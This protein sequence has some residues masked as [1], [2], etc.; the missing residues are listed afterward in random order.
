LNPKFPDFHQGRESQRRGSTMLI[1][2]LGLMPYRQAWALQEEAHAQVLT[3]GEERVLLVE[4]PPVITFGRRA[5]V[6]RNLIASEEQLA[7]M[8]VEVVQSDRGGDITFHGPGQIVAYPIVRLNDHRLS[9]GGYVHGLERAV[10]DTLADLAIPARVDPAAVG[11]WTDDGGKPAKVC[12]IGVR[13]KRGVS[14]HGV[15]L[16][17]ETDLRYFDLI[18]PCG[19]AESA[20]TSIAKLQGIRAPSISVV[21]KSLERHLRHWLSM[22]ISTVSSGRV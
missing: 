2:D 7:S 10:I 6:A 9:V 11:V 13:I 8:G 14:L 12:A 20:V 17:V 19:L 15:A 4:H 18:V 3:G 22:S 5:G 21:K 1:H 16:N